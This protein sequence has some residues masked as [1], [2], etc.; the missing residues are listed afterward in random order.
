MY[1]LHTWLR[2]FVY[3]RKPTTRASI[4]LLAEKMAEIRR[5]KREESR[6]RKKAREK[7]RRQKRSRRAAK[8]L[9]IFDPEESDYEDV[10][11]DRFPVF[12]MK[13]HRPQ[14]SGAQTSIGDGR[15]G[16]SPVA[17]TDNT[18]KGNKSLLKR[19]SPGWK[20]KIKCPV[21][22][23]HRLQQQGYIVEPKFVESILGR[24]K[25]VLEDDAGG[26]IGDLEM[27]M[28]LFKSKK[29]EGLFDK[30]DMLKPP[31]KWVH[32][33]RYRTD[34]LPIAREMASLRQHLHVEYLCLGVSHL[35]VPTKWQT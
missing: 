11:L 1:P 6:A 9:P 19:Y 31:D 23:R 29:D 35:S 26:D 13:L 15:P 10:E 18:P 25:S 4:N 16:T 30:R 8:N 21:H 14:S 27:E 33:P 2:Q 22:Y 32:Y 34:F 17:T 24:K 7:E 12:S 20:P 28:A 3:Q 5:R